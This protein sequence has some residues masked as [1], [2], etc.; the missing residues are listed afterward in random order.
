MISTQ[1][2]RAFKIRVHIHSE[3]FHKDAHYA[4]SWHFFSYNLSVILLL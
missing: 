4:T 1:I 3:L 2:N